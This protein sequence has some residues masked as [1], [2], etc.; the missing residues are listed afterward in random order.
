MPASALLAFYRDADDNPIVS[1]LEPWSREETGG[2]GGGVMT[3]TFVWTERYLDCGLER[4]PW[5][6]VLLFIDVR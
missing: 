1:I 4:L 3:Q 2:A 5:P 6:V